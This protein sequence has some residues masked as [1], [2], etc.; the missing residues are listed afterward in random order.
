METYGIEFGEPRIVKTIRGERLVRSGKP[1]EEFWATWNKKKAEL[2][3]AGISVTKTNGGYVVNYWQEPDVEVKNERIDASK[4]TSSDFKG[5]VPEGLEPFGYQNAGVEYI[6]N[7]PNCL[8]ADEMGLGKTI[9]AIIAWN[10]VDAKRV[11]VICPATLKLNWEIEVKKWSVKPY[12][13]HVVGPAKWKP[14]NSEYQV[15][16]INYDILKKYHAFVHGEDWDYVAIDEAHFVKSPKAIRS[17]EVLGKEHTK[18]EKKEA[19]IWNERNP[20]D[21]MEVPVDI[22]PLRAKRKLMITGTPRGSKTKDLFPLLHY[23][24]PVEW[25]NF[26]KFALRYCGAHKENGYW[27]FDGSSNLDELNARLRSTIMIRRLKA[28]VLKDLPDKLRQPIV[29]GAT[30]REERI[31]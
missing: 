29:W 18:K 14:F 17:I 5:L 28:D 23:L 1:T 16:I 19:E 2:K 9:Q 10:M 21:K 24:D 3:E 26:F 20:R 22:P 30:S 27:N 6:L 25:D 8:L 15:V 11:L 4:E 31:Q 13:V 7:A 12:S